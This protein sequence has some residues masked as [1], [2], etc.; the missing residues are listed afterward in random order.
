MSRKPP[1]K[2]IRELR[3]EVGF[4]CPVEGCGS[5]F[6]EFHHFSPP[7]RNGNTHRAE[8]MIALCQ[9]HH[10]QADGG[11]FTNAQL[12]DL[13]RNGKK[14]NK[15]LSGKFNWMRDQLLAIISGGCHLDPTVI[16]RIKDRDVIWFERDK[17]GSFLLNFDCLTITGEDR[18]C[19]RNNQW[20]TTGNEVDIICPPSGKKIK[21]EYSNGDFFEINFITIQD[22]LDFESRYNKNAVV[23]QFAKFPLTVVHLR[24]NIE[25][26]GFNMMD[27]HFKIGESHLS[28]STYKTSPALVLA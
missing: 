24:F 13:K 18:A 21:V 28:F 25:G 9:L 14:R 6:L 19:M 20:F 27:D 8:G 23:D 1:R 5:P 4:C 2:I 7:W 16:L 26:S 12:I 11:A 22:S 3:K 10:D 17:N 15:K